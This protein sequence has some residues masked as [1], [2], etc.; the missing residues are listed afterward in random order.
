MRKPLRSLST[1]LILAAVLV[2]PSLAQAAP[3]AAEIDRDVNAALKNLYDTSPAA[4]ALRKNA[5]GILVFPG[6]VK[7]GFIVGAQYGTGALREKGKTV[8]YYNTVGG[9]FGLQ[10]G[11][12]KFSY[13][14]FFMTDEGLKYLKK[15]KGWEFGAG[16]TVTVVDEGVA[17]SLSTTTAREGIYV[18]FYGQSGLMAGISLEGAKITRIHP[19]K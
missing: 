2:L 3:T 4:R 10:I 14:M 16:P 17:K 7:G 12:Q 13:A 11:A 1:A 18:F 8:G 9:S 15:S 5:K 6:V 19:A